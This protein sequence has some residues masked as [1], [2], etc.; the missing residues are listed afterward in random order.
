MRLVSVNVSMGTEVEW[1]GREVTTGIFK[2]AVSGRVMVRHGGVEGDRQADLSVHGGEYKA[3]YAYAREHYDWWRTELGR[4][5]SYGM[6]GE[7]LTID[8][9]PELEVSVGDTIRVGS[10][11][12]EAV[13]PR[14]PCYK[15]VIRFADDSIQRRFL[16]SGR[17]GV[18]FRVL[19]EGFVK[20]GDHVRF[21]YRDPHAIPVRD[22][23]RLL[24][25]PGVAPEEI[26]R[27]LEVTSLPPQ[28]AHKLRARLG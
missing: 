22:L 23:P 28:W 24:Q 9:L 18:Y 27:A 16:E 17:W 13:Q 1:Q 11:L 5:L 3:V 12:L 4:E 8:E 15:L 2:R 7:N 25:D 10:A 19:E 21:E 14:Q 20:A 26:G 6:F